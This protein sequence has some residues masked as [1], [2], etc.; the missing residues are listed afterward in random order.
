[1]I[2]LYLCAHHSIHYNLVGL[3]P[4]PLP[5]PSYKPLNNLVTR[6][7][8][9]EYLSISSSFIDKEK[10]G[11]HSTFSRSSNS[12]KLHLSSNQNSIRCR[13]QTRTPLVVEYKP[14]L[15][16][17]QS[18]NQNSIRG[19]VQTRTL[20][21]VEFKPERHQRQSSNQNSIRGRV[22]IRTPLERVPPETPLEVEFIPELQKRK[23]SNQNCIRGRVQTRTT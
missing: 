7:I 17:R 18:T 11:W 2:I 8:I 13:V 23:N 22:Q 15:H 5:P 16:Q 14:E 9:L 6:Y 12:Y 4:L 10:D 20:L 3:P 1:M 21:Q 19:R